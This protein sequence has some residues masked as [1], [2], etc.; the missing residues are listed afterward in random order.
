[1]KTLIYEIIAAAGTIEAAG[2]RILK[3]FGLTPMTFN[4]LNV[5]KDAPLSQRGN[6][7]VIHEL[8]AWEGT[9]PQDVEEELIELRR[10]S[11]ASKDMREGMRAFAE[12]RPARWLGE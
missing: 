4:I 6:K 1:M 12:K 11:F 8:L 2:T 5:L 9:L 3:P 7:R 10:A